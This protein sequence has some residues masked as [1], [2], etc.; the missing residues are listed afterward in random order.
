[1]RILTFALILF[2]CSVWAQ[3]QKRVTIAQPQLLQANAGTD[4]QI[5]SG[6]SITIG[7]NPSAKFGT[8]GYIYLW[9]P[10]TSLSSFTSSNP[11]AFPIQTTIYIL[12]VTDNK[13][14]TDFDTTI[15]TVVPAGIEESFNANYFE[16]SYDKNTGYITVSNNSLCNFYNL[17]TSVYNILGQVLFTSTISGLPK[18]EKIRI[19]C[20]GYPNGAYILKIDNKKQIVFKKFTTN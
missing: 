20:S 19:N 12:S 17:K 11:S 1:M 13:G 16:I 3:I 2:N 8:P 18:N 14:C 10:S 6:N 4:K 9:Q 7:G 5:I 15:V